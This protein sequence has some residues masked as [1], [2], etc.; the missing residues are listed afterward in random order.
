MCVHGFIH[1]LIW[2]Q[3]VPVNIMRCNGCCQAAMQD[4]SVELLTQILV[5]YANRSPKRRTLSL[6]PAKIL[7]RLTTTIS[8]CL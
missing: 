2:V 5:C 3:H 8:L 1:A 4:A 6:W 7:A